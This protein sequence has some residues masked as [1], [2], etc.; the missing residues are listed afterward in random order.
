MGSL[1]LNDFQT[2]I[3]GNPYTLQNYF[4]VTYGIIKGQ[5]YAFRYRGINAIGPGLWSDIAILKAATVPAPPGEPYYI[6]STSNSITIGFLPSLDDG[7][8]LINEYRLFRDA[9]NLTSDINT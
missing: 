4:V 5:S 1:T 9:G 7:G 2:I 8:S 6:S 3:G